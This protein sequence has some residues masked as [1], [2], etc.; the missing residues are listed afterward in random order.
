MFKKQMILLLSLII[1][2]IFIVVQYPEN[3]VDQFISTKFSQ[4][5]NSLLYRVSYYLT[6]LG[7]R[8]II[9]PLTLISGVIFYYHFKRIFPSLI[10]AG[11]TLVAFTL[12][13]LIKSIIQR[14]RPSLLIDVHATGFSFPS[15]HAMISCV[16]YG[17][18]CYYLIQFPF[19]SMTKKVIVIVSVGLIAIIG[20]TRMILNVHYFTDIIGG[21]LI[22]GLFFLMIL[23]FVKLQK[24]V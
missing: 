21:Y 17:L 12:N 8:N 24:S 18:L 9:I 22:G 15:G 16:C 2:L 23:N 19:N 3:I 5:D 20:L 11:G 10:L 13:E 4:Q 7:S 6:F 1:I 14:Q